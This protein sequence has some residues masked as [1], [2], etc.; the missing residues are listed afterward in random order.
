MRTNRRYIRGLIR[1]IILKEGA[2]DPG[3]PTTSAAPQPGMPPG[4]S[5]A[6]DY[7]VEFEHGDTEEYKRGYQD[8]LDG[9]PMADDANTD[10]DGGYEDGESDAKLSDDFPIPRADPRLK[11]WRQ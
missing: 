5:E 10:Y 7:D 6:D 2:V 8:G 4:V 1:R 9:Y 3:K 11:K